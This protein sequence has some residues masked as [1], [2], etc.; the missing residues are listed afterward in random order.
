MQPSKLAKL[1]IQVQMGIRQAATVTSHRWCLTAYLRPISLQL[2][3]P[4]S[5]FA[6]SWCTGWIINQ[7]LKDSF[8]LIHHFVS[9]K[10]ICSLAACPSLLGKVFMSSSPTGIWLRKFSAHGTL[11]SARSHLSDF[12]L[13]KSALS[14]KWVIIWITTLT[15]WS[16]KLFNKSMTYNNFI[17]S[18]GW[19]HRTNKQEV[20]TFGHCLAVV[21]V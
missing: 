11:K 3:L 4:F 14:S 1:L 12:S 8:T 17:T 21:S 6:S 20:Y 2:L 16:M 5:L 7:L 19:T 18:H 13:R 15:M 10:V 9:F